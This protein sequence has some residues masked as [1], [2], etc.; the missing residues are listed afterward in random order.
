M[1]RLTD[2]FDLFRIFTV[3]IGCCLLTAAS[4]SH[5]PI[6]GGSEF[7]LAAGQNTQLVGGCSHPIS[8]GHEYCPVYRGADL[9]TIRLTFTNQT[10]YAVGDCDGGLFYSGI[11]AIPGTY[12]VDLSSLT[13]Q[14][15]KR[16]FCFI[17]IEALESYADPKDSSQ[18]RLIGHS[19][20]VIIEILAPNYIPNPAPDVQAFCYRVSRTTKGR[21]D[22]KKVSCD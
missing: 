15:N 7:A 16:G 20:W 17:H 9:P 1:K 19:G 21:T 10:E 4:C 11:A 8:I 6:D 2:F 14:A 13:A 3:I 18:R 22:L 5:I 12:E